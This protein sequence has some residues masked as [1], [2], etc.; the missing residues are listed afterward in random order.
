MEMFKGLGKSQTSFQNWAFSTN[1]APTAQGSNFQ[2]PKSGPLNSATSK[3]VGKC[4]F[5]LTKMSVASLL[6]AL[7]IS[8]DAKLVI[9][10]QARSLGLDCRRFGPEQIQQDEALELITSLNMHIPTEVKRD[11]RSKL[12]IVSSDHNS[13]NWYDPVKKKADPTNPV[14]FERWRRLYQCTAGSDNTTGHHAGKRR[15]MSWQDVGCP[16]F[17]KLTST[18]HGKKDDSMILTIDEIF[19]D[20]THSAACQALTKMEHNPRVP[21]HPELRQYAISLL[22]IR[23]P[24]TQLKQLCCSWAQNKWGSAA[25]DNNFPTPPLWFR[26]LNPQPPDP[27]LS[28]SCLFYS[29]HIIG[30]TDRFHLILST[31]EQKLLAWKY[32]HKQ[33]VLMDLTF[34]ICSGRVLLALLMAIHDQNHG[35]PIAAFLFSAKPKAKAVHAD[36]NTALLQKLL[37]EWKKGM[38]R[39][40]AGEEFEIAVGNTDNDA[41]E[42][43]ALQETWA[44]IMLLLCMFHVWQAWRNGL[45]K[46]LREEVR[47]Q[48][49]KFLMRLLKDIDIY[50]DAVAHYNAEIRYFKALAAKRTALQ[51]QQGNA[52][53]SF[54]SYFQSYLKLRDFWLAWSVAG[55]QQAAA[56]LGV[57]LTAIARTNNH[58]ESFNG[59]I[60]GKFFA[61][62]MRGGRLPR[63]DYWILV[64]IT[65]WA[66]RRALANY[67]TDLRHLPS[68]ASAPT[69]IQF[70][71]RRQTINSDTLTSPSITTSSPPPLPKPATVSEAHSNAEEWVKRVLPMTLAADSA[72]TLDPCADA[73]EEYFEAVEEK[74]VEEMEISCDEISL[75]ANLPD[76]PSG[77]STSPDNQ[78]HSDL[79]SPHHCRFPSDS[80][81]SSSSISLADFALDSTEI[82]LDLN[83]IEPSPSDN[84]DSDSEFNFDLEDVK[85][86]NEAVNDQQRATAMM[87]LQRQ[88]D[89][90]AA[91]IRK[92][93]DLGVARETLQRHISDS[94]GEQ[95][96][97]AIPPEISPQ[98]LPSH[99]PHHRTEHTTSFPPVLLP[100]PP[101]PKIPD[102][103]HPN[104]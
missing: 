13:V 98:I 6:K 52:G 27:R 17:V 73:E 38:G 92:L 1:C 61:H 79:L 62:H 51:K 5:Q 75:D 42:R 66:E 58:L 34:G 14:K 100:L 39:N 33:Q 82:L 44:A 97:R 41:R 31:P 85:Q 67:Y 30:E 54:L 48:L 50:E 25:G 11:A 65:E 68:S 104:I 84:S 40:E 49:G 96:F 9:D 10:Q 94:I 15:D 26:S 2:A 23:V 18:H 103:S 16:F 37:G 91:T 90:L 60:K 88:E 53:I 7:R 95:L 101:I 71:S 24:L 47:Q 86:K 57:P 70:D 99:D 87:E 78:L 83:G 32:A 36:Y 81:S 77:P 59:R 80:G 35:I 4:K 19:G 102:H 63:L 8:E 22:E 89:D 21:L 29:P 56:R 64:Y 28:A 69:T 43:T 45:I 72:V 12:V 55:V 20:F 3:M 46:H 93:L 74:E 76:S